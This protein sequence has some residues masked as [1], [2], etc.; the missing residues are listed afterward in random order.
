M[1]NQRSPDLDPYGVL[2]CTEGLDVKGG[3]SLPDYEQITLAKLVQQAVKFRPIPAS[4]GSLLPMDPSL[5]NLEWYGRTA[6][7]ACEKGATCRTD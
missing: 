6:G 4:T 2:A 3:V 1:A 5:C 7:A